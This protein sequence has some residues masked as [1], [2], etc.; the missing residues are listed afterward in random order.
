MVRTIDRYV[1]R[2]VIPPFLLA[3]LILTFLLVLPPVM[4]HLEKLLAKGV[5]WTTAGRIIWTLVPQA[6]RP[7]DPDVAA[8]RPAGR[9]RPAVGRPGSGRAPGLRRQP[10]PAAPAGH[11]LSAPSPAP[12]PLYVMMVAIPDANQTFRELTFDVIAKRVENDI[13]PRVF[14]QDFPGWVLYA[15]RRADPRQRVEGRPRRRHQ[16]AGRDRMLPGA[17]GRLV[18]NREPSGQVDLVLDRRHPVF[19]RQD[20]GRPIRY[21]S[22]ASLVHGAEPGHRCSASRL[23]RGLNEKT[24]AELR[25]TWPTK[26]SSS[27]VSPHPEIIQLEQKFSIPV[28]CLVFALIGLALGLSVA[29]DGK[30]AGF[31]VGIA[32]IFA[33]YIV[34]PLAEALTKGHYASPARRSAAARFLARA[35]GALVAQHGPGGLRPGALIWRAAMPRAS[36]PLRMPAIRRAMW[37][38]ARDAAGT[39]QPRQRP[40]RAVQ[41]ARGVARRRRR[42]RPHPPSRDA[43]ARHPRPLHQP[44]LPAGRR[45]CRSWRCSGMF[46]ISTF[47]DTSDKLFKGQA[48]E[49]H[50]HARCSAY[51]TPQF[52]YYV[53]PHRGAA[54][55]ARDLRPAVADQRA[56]GHEGLRHQPLSHRRCRSLLLSLVLSGVALRPRAAGPGQAPTGGPTSLDA[57]IRGRPPRTSTPLNRRW[58]VGARRRHLPLRRTSTPRSKTMLTSTVYPPAEGRAGARDAS[59]SQRASTIERPAGMAAMAGAG[60]HRPTRRPGPAFPQRA[61]GRIEPPDYFKTAAAARRDDDRA[62]ARSA[63]STSFGQ[64]RQRR[65]SAGRPAQEARLPVCHLRDDAAGGALWRHHRQARHAL[66]HRPRHR[67]SRCR[68]WI[69]ISAFVAIGKAGAAPPVLAGWAPNILVARSA[70]PTYS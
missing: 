43:G 27:R 70:L 15:A 45:R 53:I 31:V 18:L 4:E 52:V 54:E 33:Y 42:G 63:T 14:F 8:G 59:C 41:A 3:L 32:V 13:Q 21:G 56:D 5:S 7:D 51:M 26:L 16:Q 19:D 60:L 65:P 37:L 30:L 48:T 24:I 50:R 17:R 38:E 34:I 10:L 6:A 68:Y 44:D 11:W 23:P 57:Q 1:I 28:A 40:R 20:R 12:R 64:R 62:A 39:G 29:R 25:R 55:R 47:I 2:E 58:V 61:L 67:A 46:Y 66:R 35:P 49:R 22:Q 36:I 69:V 9:P